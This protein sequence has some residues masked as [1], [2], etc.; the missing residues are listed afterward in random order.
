MGSEDFDMLQL[1][2]KLK[3]HISSGSRQTEQQSHEQTSK[4]QEDTRESLGQHIEVSPD[5]TS[6]KILRPPC[7]EQTSQSSATGRSE[8]NP[9]S[10]DNP[11]PPWQ[12][13]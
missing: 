10:K 2:G 11:P 1:G 12:Q 9:L 13:Y 3:Y 5:A 6:D 7:S 8:E 4:V